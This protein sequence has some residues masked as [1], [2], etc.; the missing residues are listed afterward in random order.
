[1]LGQRWWFIWISNLDILCRRFCFAYRHTFPPQNSGRA[2][3]LGATFRSL[4]TRGAS[5]SPLT[6]YSLKSQPRRHR[7]TPQCPAAACWV[8]KSVCGCFGRKSGTLVWLRGWHCLASGCG[9]WLNEASAHRNRK[10]GIRGRIWGILEEEEG[11]G[12]HELSLIKGF[13]T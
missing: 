1:M 3:Q 5:S 10:C 11:S 4:I 12:R 13:R 6:P 7:L 8:S 9:S 2:K